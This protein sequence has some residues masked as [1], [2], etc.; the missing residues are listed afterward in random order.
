MCLLHALLRGV[1]VVPRCPRR[2]H[3]APSSW[4]APLGSLCSAARSAAHRHAVADRE[5]SERVGLR[6]LLGVAI[7]EGAGVI[8]SVS[9][10]AC[11]GRCGATVRALARAVRRGAASPSGR[12]AARLRVDRAFPPQPQR[13][14]MPHRAHL[15]QDEPISLL[16]LRLRGARRRGRLRVGLGRCCSCCCCCRCCCWPAA[17]RHADPAAVHVYLGHRARGALSFRGRPRRRGSAAASWQDFKERSW[18]WETDSVCCATTRL[19]CVSESGEQN[20]VRLSAFVVGPD[21]KSSWSLSSASEG[22]RPPMTVAASAAAG[23]RARRRRSS[24][25]PIAAAG[26]NSGMPLCC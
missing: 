16:R 8:Q 23:A 1:A 19:L 26:A 6:D 17:G 18:C 2:R 13:H 10:S 3:S 25:R 11:G 22:Q 12:R 21:A 4:R 14:P 15:V 7:G 24:I 5:P 20:C 9:A